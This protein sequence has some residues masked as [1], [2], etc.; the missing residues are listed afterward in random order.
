MVAVGASE[1]SR[2]STFFISLKLGSTGA[3]KREKVF[4]MQ[5]S[6]AGNVTSSES[7]GGGG[8]ELGILDVFP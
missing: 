7:V 6:N 2:W 4:D 5:I 8:G 1:E 3:S